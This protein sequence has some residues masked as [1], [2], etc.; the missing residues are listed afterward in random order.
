[1]K[2]TLSRISFLTILLTAL[3]FSILTGVFAFYITGNSFDRKAADLEERYI[4]ENKRLVKQEVQRLVGEITFIDSL[5]ARTTQT[6]LKERVDR[7]AR[8]MP[9]CSAKRAGS[10]CLPVSHE[11]KRPDSGSFLTITDTQGTIRYDSRIQREHRQDSLLQLMSRF[12]AQDTFGTYPH[13]NTS[14]LL[15][16]T[17]RIDSLNAVIS[18]GTT[19]QGVRN[20]VEEILLQNIRRDRFGR[21]GMGYFWIHTLQGEMVMHPLGKDLF[22]ADLDTFTNAEGRHIFREMDSAATQNSGGFVRYRWRLPGD[23][24][25]DTKISFVQYI[26]TYDIVVGAG[27]YMKELRQKRRGE[28][29]I[30]YESLHQNMEEL[31]TL[32]AVLFLLSTIG[33]WMVSRRIGKMETRQRHNDVL[34]KQYRQILDHSALV[35]RTDTD[36]TIVYVNDAFCRVSG[37]H[38]NELLGRPHNIVRHPETPRSRFR[39]LWA[40]ISAGGVWQGVLKNRA[41]DGESYYSNT[42]ILPLRDGSGRISGYISAAT[43]VTELLEKREQLKKVFRTDPLTGLGSRSALLER[44]ARG[45]QAVLA[46]IN[47]DRFRE[48][49]DIHGHTLG[50]GIITAFADRLFQAIPDETYTLY[51]VQADVFALFTTRESQDAVYSRVRTFISSHD[52]RTYL[53]DNNRFIVTYTAGIARG[54]Q[55]QLNYAD[56]ALSEAKRS[57]VQIQIFDE[58]LSHVEDYRRNIAWVERLHRALQ[59]ERIVPYYQPIYNYRTGTVEKYECLMR[60]MEEGKPVPPGEYLPVAKKTRLYPELTYQMISQAITRFSS[61]D[62]D[63]SLNLSVEDLM[64]RELMIY[65]YDFAEQKGVFDRLILEIVESEEIKDSDSVTKTLKRFKEQGGR[66]AIDDFGTGYSNYDYLIRLNADFIKI[67][68]SI[69]TRITDDPRAVDIV[70]SVVKFARNSG[71][72]TVAE[73]ISSP[74]LSRKAQEL[75]VDYAQGFFHGRPAPTLQVTADT[76]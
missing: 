8:L 72:Q 59:E 52:N 15:V 35:S 33:A 24:V 27:F 3:V 67:D 58:T 53:I 29:R 37:Y 10:L 1:M 11:G 69:I 50:D 62:M 9:G 41:K 21:N 57:H 30:L 5:A 60:L 55:D 32:L 12:D 17:R 47:I 39:H 76:E 65:L 74:Q 54:L 31:L 71:M 28:R 16:Y 63:F 42:T 26:D 18:A 49:N 36:G 4:A 70:R 20:A 43:E 19:R 13:E 2:M 38:R 25:T 7:A 40:T 75:G 48:I 44:T 45:E 56:M 23:T 34:L 68:G 22:P 64:N 61:T 51:R 73:F 46:L 6:F 66:I 14:Q